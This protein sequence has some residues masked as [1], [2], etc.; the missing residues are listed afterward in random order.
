MA[1]LSFVTRAGAYFSQVFFCSFATCLYARKKCMLVSAS[2]HA[3]LHS[4]LRSTVVKSL[5]GKL[6]NDASTSMN[7]VI[8]G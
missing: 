5:Q 7:E 4:A 6:R 1:F 8:Q 2:E 3:I